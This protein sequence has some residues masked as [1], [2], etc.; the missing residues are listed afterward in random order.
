MTD[1][2]LLLGKLVIVG[3]VGVA[4]FYIFSGKLSS[5]ALYQLFLHVQET[6]VVFVAMVKSIEMN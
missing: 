1:F 4:S 2:L 5:F 6:T 3:A